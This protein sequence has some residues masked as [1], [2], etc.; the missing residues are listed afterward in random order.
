MYTWLRFEVC[1]PECSAARLGQR[2]SCNIYISGWLQVKK[3]KTL[4]S[5]GL[6]LLVIIVICFTKQL[7]TQPAG[8]NCPGSCL[9][10]LMRFLLFMCMTAHNELINQTTLFCFCLSH[11][12]M[13]CL[14]LG[15]PSVL[16]TGHFVLYFLFVHSQL[17]QRCIG[18]WCACHEQVLHQL[19]KVI[20]CGES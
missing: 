7:F 9:F 17:W 1:K 8:W 5:Y 18:C 11:V 3:Q 15:E 12:D 6:M 19:Q 16:P 20:S 13:S 14:V 2:S 4:Y 10:A